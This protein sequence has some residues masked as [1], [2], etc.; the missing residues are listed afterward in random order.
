MNP[1]FPIY[2]PTK[3]RSTRRLTINALERMG[4]PYQIIVEGNEYADYADVVSQDKILLL[5]H[6]YIQDYDTCDDLGKT[7]PVGS[8]AAR[9][10]AWEHSIQMGY[11]YHWVIDDNISGFGRLNRNLYIPVTSGTIFYIIEDFVQRYTNIAI[12]SLNYDFFAKAKTVIPP[13][14]LN[15]RNYSCMLICN[16]IPFR[17]RGRYNED[18]DL[19]LRVLK[20]SEYCT[21]QFNAFL[22]EKATTQTIKGGNTSAFYEKEG[23]LP[24]SQMLKRLHPD[25]VD[26]VWKFKRWHHQVDYRQFKQKKL[27]RKQGIE[28]PDRVNNF[29]M[30]VRKIK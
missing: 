27:I 22:Q 28:I 23:T 24:K 15:T 5:P 3:G 19:C 2:I 21:I 18:T 25:V 7:K 11:P 9:N 16:E 4:V 12:A 6:K 8:G 26:V 10:F 30:V 20:E 17:W 29:G 1:Q 14:V 13:Y